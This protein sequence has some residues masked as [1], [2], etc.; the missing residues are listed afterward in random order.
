MKNLVQRGVVIGAVLMGLGLTGA[1]SAADGR[2]ERGHQSDRAGHVEHD[3]SQ[4][5]HERGGRGERRRDY[6]RGR[7]CEQPSYRRGHSRGKNFVYVRPGRKV[8]IIRSGDS[9]GERRRDHCR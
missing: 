6:D 2:G 5:G 1:A 8:I 7:G 9:C 4:L 3:R